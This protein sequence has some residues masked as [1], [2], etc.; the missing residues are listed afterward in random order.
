MSNRFNSEL[1]RNLK[2]NFIVNMCDGSFF[3]FGLGFA[4]FTAIIPLF[5]SQMTSSPLL[6]GLIPAIHSVGWQLPQLFS[7]KRISRLTHLKPF[8]LLMTTQER[9]PFLGLAAL[10][11]FMPAIGTTGTLVLTFMLLVW[12]GLGA[13]FAANA[14]QNMIGKVFPAETRA[15]F[16][17]MQTAASNLTG[18]AGAVVAGIIL[19]ENPSNAGFAGCFLICILLMGISWIFL[20]TTREPIY[21]L[22]D[23]AIEQPPLWSNVRQ[24]LRNDRPFLG[25]LMS[26]VL[27]QFGMMGFSFYIVYAVEVIHMDVATAGVMTG[28][29]L[30][31]QVVANPI[32]GWIAD[33]W[34]HKGVLEI[35]AAA[36]MLSAGL[37]WLAPGMAAFPLV[38][39]LEGIA[40]TTF[41]TVGLAYSLSFGP[42]HARPTYVGIVNTLGAP[43]AIIAPLLGGWLADVSGYPATFLASA[44]AS[45]VTAL[46]LH[47]LIV[48]PAKQ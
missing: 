15:T 24:I 13:G 37:A 42:E 2:H 1:Q 3:G 41:W 32:L 23:P 7:A 10:A 31:T 35:G 12:Q 44:V 30:F 43:A 29:L 25:F 39:I 19:E 6:I 9:L 38:M 48:T 47:F 40:V 5:V 18:S 28:I 20:R 14:W 36:S 22:A 16:F 17:G 33:H 11:W 46:V 21:S 45:L 8:V 4:S 34:N 26:R 27:F